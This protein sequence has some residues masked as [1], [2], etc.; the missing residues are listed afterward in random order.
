MRLAIFRKV[1][2]TKFLNEFQTKK[3]FI[4]KNIYILEIS[5]FIDVIV[6]HIV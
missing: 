5:I 6:V 4:Q 2:N 1:S 3:Y